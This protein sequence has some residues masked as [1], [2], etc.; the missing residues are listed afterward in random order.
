MDRTRAAT[1]QVEVAWG[2][3]SH[4]GCPSRS[5]GRTIRSGSVPIL[6][7]TPRPPGPRKSTD[8]EA[9][10]DCTAHTRSRFKKLKSPSSSEALFGSRNNEH[11]LLP[12]MP[13]RN[14][15]LKNRRA[16]TGQDPDEGSGSGSDS[17]EPSRR[18]ASSRRRRSAAAAAASG[19]SSNTRLRR[20]L[21]ILVLTTALLAAYHGYRLYARNH[22]VKG[23][24]DLDVQAKAHGAPGLNVAPAAGGGMVLHPTANDEHD[25]VSDVRL[26]DLDMET[27]QAAFDALYGDGGPLGPSAKRRQGSDEGQYRVQGQGRKEQLN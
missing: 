11:V 21:A 6:P 25:D 24:R 2:T 23:A 5:D 7:P 12:I 13:S 19:S 22:K 14:S 17:T 26:E 3:T 16:L 9:T 10:R 20:L 15:R 4:V 27:L 18:A 8:V 1:R